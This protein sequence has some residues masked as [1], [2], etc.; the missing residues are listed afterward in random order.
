MATEPGCEL[1]SDLGWTFA[2][3]DQGREV[4]Q[5]C[6]ACAARRPVPG[7][8]KRYDGA[9]WATWEDVPEVR[10]QVERIR[11]WRGGEDCWCVVL[12]AD[13]RSNLGAGKTRLL[14]TLCREWRDLGEPAR[15]LPVEQ[16]FGAERERMS[17]LREYGDVCT[18]EW[19]KRF[20]GLLALDDVGQEHDDK[21]GWAAGVLEELVDARYAGLLPL[22][23]ATNL[24]LDG[25]RVRYPR[26]WSRV[27]QGLLCPWTAPD[28]R[29]HPRHIAEPVRARGCRGT[30]S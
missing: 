21:A 1:C 30:G 10:D 12:H 3:D 2:R 26:L 4:C 11:V 6:S 23:A 18:L 24:D 15:Y 17:G 16:L 14:V 8:P 28:F 20:A 13:G 5:P 25:L 22:I 29:R 7:I 19:A 27:H 9:S